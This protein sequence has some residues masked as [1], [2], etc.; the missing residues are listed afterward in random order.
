MWITWW[1]KTFSVPGST[2]ISKEELETVDIVLFIYF[3]FLYT[4][5][6]SVRDLFLRH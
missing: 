4:F 5:S 2:H 1:E 3:F 6:S